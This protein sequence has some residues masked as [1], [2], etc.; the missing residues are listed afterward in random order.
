M[1]LKRRLLLA[2]FSVF[3]PLG[4]AI[5][6]EPA[7]FLVEAKLWIGGE[8]MGT[9]SLIVPANSPGSV[10]VG[11]VDSGWRLGV[12]VEPVTDAYAPADTLWMHVD[13][14]QK[15]DGQ[16]E[17]VADS[18]LGV[19]EGEN[20]TFSVVEGKQAATAESASLYLQISAR[21]VDGA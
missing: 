16:W 13:I 15:I 6:A 8:Q 10:E 20:A 14:H 18:L 5:A 21:S 7:R 17:V 1:S 9:P 2:V 19:P 4:S 3:L 11:D 12:L